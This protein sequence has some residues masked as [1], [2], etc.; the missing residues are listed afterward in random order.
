[1]IDVDSYL[2]AHYRQSYNCAHFVRDVWATTFGEDISEVVHCPRPAKCLAVRPLRGFRLVR[3]AGEVG[4]VLMRTCVARQP[5]VGVMYRGK[6]LHLQ[7]RGA[8]YTDIH[9]ASFGYEQ[10]RYYEPC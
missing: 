7:T 10:V 5:H 2:G 6:I 1:M 4:L 9:V 3:A 8:E